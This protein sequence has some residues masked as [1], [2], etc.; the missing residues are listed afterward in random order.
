[1][2]TRI[3]FDSKGRPSFTKIDTG[4]FVHNMDDY[5]KVMDFTEAERAWFRKP[6]NERSAR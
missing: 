4:K 5:Y 2:I 3:V 1:M 6:I